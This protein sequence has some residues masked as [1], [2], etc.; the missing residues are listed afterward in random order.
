MKFLITRNVIMVLFFLL[1][2]IQCGNNFIN[3][4]FNLLNNGIIFLLELLHQVLYKW[5][6]IGLHKWLL[7]VWVT[8][9]QWL[10]Q[11]MVIMKIIHNMNHKAPCNMVVKDELATKG[12]WQLLIIRVTFQFRRIHLTNLK[13]FIVN[14]KKWINN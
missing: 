1:H 14:T 11:W 6:K 9:L 3:L 8:S 5:F 12:L 2:V 4:I 7:K 13:H 10:V